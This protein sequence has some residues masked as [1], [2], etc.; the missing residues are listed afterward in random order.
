MGRGGERAIFP[1]QRRGEKFIKSSAVSG[2]ARHKN[3]RN[4]PACVPFCAARRAVFSPT[5]LSS[6]PIC[7][8]RP[9]FSCSAPQVVLP[10]PRPFWRAVQRGPAHQSV[11]PPFPPLWTGR[12]KSTGPRG[13]RVSPLPL[14]CTR[15]KGAGCT[16]ALLKMGRRLYARQ[17]EGWRPPPHRYGWPM[18]RGRPPRESGGRRP[19]RRR[20]GRRLQ[21]PQPPGRRPRRRRRRA[22]FPGRSPR[23]PR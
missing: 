7:S 12:P 6:A 3:G 5:A 13:G 20:A 19:R 10:V 14:L 4:C 23:P 11:Q 16:G 15:Q 2:A 9:F 1:P 8:P 22:R 21:R 17:E 18:R